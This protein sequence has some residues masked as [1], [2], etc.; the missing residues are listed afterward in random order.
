M[1]HLVA[2]ILLSL[3]TTA[4]IL[5]IFYYLLFKFSDWLNRHYG[6]QIRRL[7]KQSLQETSNDSP[8]AREYSNYCIYPAYLLQKISELYQASKRRS[9]ALIKKTGLCEPIG[10]QE[11]KSNSKYDSTNIKCRSH[12]YS[13]ILKFLRRKVNENGKEPF[14]STLMFYDF[15]TLKCSVKMSP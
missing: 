2:I 1:H 13:F 6:V 15:V 5:I 14:E 12:L 11:E 3:I 9:R 7:L 8:Q 4:V 10:N